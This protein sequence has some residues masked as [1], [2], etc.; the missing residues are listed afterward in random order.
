MTDKT[1]PRDVDAESYDAVAEQIGGFDFDHASMMLDIMAKATN[2][3]PK[4][5][6]IFG[7][8]QAEIE[9]LNVEAKNIALARAAA[10]KSIQA[11]INA[12]NHEAAQERKA[13]E[14]AEAKAATDA[15]DAEAR[16]PHVEPDPNASRTATIADK[17]ARR[18]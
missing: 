8:A 13:K 5:T 4:A 3:G 10:T 14:D 6:A 9:R 11:E 2:I 7:L 17:A 15:A 1:K 18:L 16:K 12:A